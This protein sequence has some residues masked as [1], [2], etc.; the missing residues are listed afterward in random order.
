M[1]QL[2][3]TVEQFLAVFHDYNE[4][5]WPVQ[6]ILLALAFLSLAFLFSQWRWSDV[7]I[8]AILG[9][10]WIWSGL[11][12][13]LAYFASINPLAYLF[14]VLFVVAGLLFLWHGAV[15]RNLHF[16]SSRSARGLVGYALISFALLV[17][18]AWSLLAGHGYPAM[19]TFGVP[20]PTTL[21]TV[22]MLAFLA[23][24]YPRTPLI[25]PV[26]WSM[27]GVQAA[28]LLGVPQDLGLLVAAVVGV[29]LLVHSG[30]PGERGEVAA[31]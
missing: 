10:F 18:P 2:P 6:M 23:R 17:Y 29:V 31:S 25:V 1:I 5:A 8:S 19:P 14:A 22:G 3:F 11:A 24:P 7:L 26:L 20:C 16:R 4:A 15:R 27:V 12:Y 21:F 28:F 9:I 30:T 13:H